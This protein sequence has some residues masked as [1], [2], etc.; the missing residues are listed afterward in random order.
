M[1]YNKSY[2]MNAVRELE[3]IIRY[4]CRDITCDECPYNSEDEIC[5]LIHNLR[6]ICPNT[7]LKPELDN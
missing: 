5:I 7:Y 3:R 2:Q 6:Y 1:K 4:G